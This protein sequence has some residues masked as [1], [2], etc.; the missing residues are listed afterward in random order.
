MIPVGVNAQADRFVIVP[1]TSPNVASTQ[2]TVQI[3]VRTAANVLFTAGPNR[4]VKL[5]VSGAAFTL[6]S[7]GIVS[8]VAGTGTIKVQD[9]NAETVT[10]SLADV[11][12]TGLAVTST[13]NLVYTNGLCLL[14]P[15]FFFLLYYSLFF[16]Y[17]LPNFC[18]DLGKCVN[19]PRFRSFVPIRFPTTEYP[20]TDCWGFSH[21]Y[22]SGPRSVW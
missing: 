8:L 4:T 3:Q 15:S 11:S 12:N 13:F 19:M 2:V 6:P 10:L 14:V 20:F 1:P 7:D 22:C 17:C 16:L 9:F 21:H 18:R 5:V